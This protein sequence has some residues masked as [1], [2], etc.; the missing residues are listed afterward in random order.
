MNWKQSG[1]F[2]FFAGRS[3]CSVATAFKRVSYVLLAFSTVPGPNRA[4]LIR[5][6][7]Q[8]QRMSRCLGVTHAH[9]MELALELALELELELADASTKLLRSAYSHL[10]Q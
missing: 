6:D 10:L 1:N 7:S 5:P 8:Q 2:V 9:A 3:W 4:V